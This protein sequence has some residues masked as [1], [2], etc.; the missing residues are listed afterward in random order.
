MARGSALNKKLHP[1]DDLAEVLG[2]SKPI[3]RGQAMKKVW[4]Y[5]KENDLQDEDDK[6]IIHPDALL[7]CVLG[8]RPLTMFDMTKKISQHL[9]E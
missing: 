8:K 3:S 4:D 1:S 7:A 9:S 6:R 5:I 2:S